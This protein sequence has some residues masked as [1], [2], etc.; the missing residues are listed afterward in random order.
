MTCL[1]CAAPTEG[2]LKFCRGSR[3]RNKH[4]SNKRRFGDA[5]L[6]ILTEPGALGAFMDWFSDYCQ[7][8]CTRP[9]STEGHHE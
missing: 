4:H 9:Q 3:C 7:T 2:D 8:A 1:H 5:I 6:F